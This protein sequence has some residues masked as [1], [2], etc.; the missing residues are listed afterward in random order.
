[1]LEFMESKRRVPVLVEPL[2]IAAVQIRERRT[3]RGKESTAVLTLFS[4]GHIR[5]ED[6]GSVGTQIKTAKA[7]EA[8][9]S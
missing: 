8:A 2:A 6:D 1:M 7:R 9:A 4:G 3:V 5:V